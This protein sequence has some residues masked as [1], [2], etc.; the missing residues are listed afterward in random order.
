[1]AQTNL[2]KLQENFTCFAIACVDLL[3]LPLIDILE[4]HVKPAD[5]YSKLNSST[6][7]SGNKL[8]RDQQDMCFI[9]P[10][11]IPDYSKFDV[12]LLY[13]LIRNLCPLKP[14]EEWGKEPDPANTQL[15]DDIERLRWFRNEKFAHA[16]SAEISDSEFKKH[17][18]YLQTVINRIQSNKRA[19]CK[20][21][22]RQHFKS[23]ENR[24]LK[25]EDF[26]NYKLFLKAALCAVQEREGT[27]NFCSI[28]SLL[29]NNL[30]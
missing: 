12:S 1:M 17:W 13:T 23:I 2:S 30:L 7:I 16:N 5:L 21:D 9:Q 27:D 28:C 15:G 26:E 11:G 14:T 10:P 4:N 3:K 24:T 29:T 25:Y 20:S 22:Y 18:T 19:G 6:L 8:R